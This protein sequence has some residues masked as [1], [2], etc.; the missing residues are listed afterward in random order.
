MQTSQDVPVADL[1]SLRTGGKAARL[2]TLEPHDR[3][4]DVVMGARANGPIWLLGYGTNCL[5][6][7][8][9]LPGTVILNQTGQVEQIGPHRFRADGGANWD[10]LV[11]GT[12]GAGLWGLE[13]AS[14]IP[15]G[16]GAAV[17][18]NIA[19]Y[20]HKVSDVFVEATLL[21]PADGSIR[22]WHKDELAFDYRSSALQ[23]PENQRFIVLDATF[24]LSQVPTKELE[25]ASALRVAADLHLQPDSLQNRRAIILETRR[26]AGSL[27]Q[28]RSAG[29]WTAGSFFKNPVVTESQLQN[30]IQHEEAGITR[31]QLLRQNQIHGGNTARVSAA[32]VLLAAG[33]HRGQTW[34]NVS[35]HP[36]HILKLENL[37]NATAQEMYDVVQHILSTVHEKLQITLEPEVRFLGEF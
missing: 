18:G 17:T 2:I 20:G 25:Y 13:F 3:L 27:L 16:V 37:G 26:R 7:D 15:G 29:P 36:D 11:Q 28:D 34:G 35:L 14:G 22:T 12:I 19:A 33:F 23:R 1:T 32:H 21:D 5:V 10:D 4:A 9:G 30:I 24:E 6:S 8:K 31:Q